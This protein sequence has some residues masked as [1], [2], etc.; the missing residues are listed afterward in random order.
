MDS[1]TTVGS[2]SHIVTSSLRVSL[3]N[4]ISRRRASC[5][6]SESSPSSNAAS[7]LGLFWWRGGRISRE[8]FKWKVLPCSLASKAA[9]Q[10]LGFLFPLLSSL[11][12]RSPYLVT[13][14]EHS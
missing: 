7:G 4:G 5:P 13:D 2:A 10:G 9:R 1:A 12:Y 6:D 11:F 14:S 3:K 8:L